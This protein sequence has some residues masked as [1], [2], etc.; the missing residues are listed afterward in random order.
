MFNLQAMGIE[1]HDEIDR[2]RLVDLLVVSTFSYPGE[3]WVQ[4]E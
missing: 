2:R 3:K 1:E 4:A